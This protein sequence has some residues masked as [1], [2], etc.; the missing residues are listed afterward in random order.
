MPCWHWRMGHAWQEKYSLT[1]ILEDVLKGNKREWIRSGGW[2]KCGEIISLQRQ[3]TI[4]LIIENYKKYQTV[5]YCTWKRAYRILKIC[6]CMSTESLEWSGSSWIKRSF[7]IGMKIRIAAT[8]GC[9]SSGF[10]YLFPQTIRVS[11]WK[12]IN[13]QGKNLDKLLTYS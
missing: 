12:N 5:M 2:V 7:S 1:L 9:R 10:L 13:P 6:F 4:I 8:R 11:Q 3:S